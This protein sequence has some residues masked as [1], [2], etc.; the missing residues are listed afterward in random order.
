MTRF[1]V[2]AVDDDPVNLHIIGET[3]ADSG[4]DVVFANGGDPALHALNGEQA[5]DLVILDRMMP[6]LDGMQLL[7][8]LKASPRHAKL[9]VIM[10]TAAATPEQVAE[11]LS[12]GAHYYLTKPYTPAALRTI[13][14][15]ALEDVQ[16]TRELEDQATLGVESMQMLDR[17]VFGFRTIAQATKVGAL[18]A[19]L[20]PSPGTAALGL[21]EILVNAVEHGN[22]GISYAEKSALKRGNRMHEELER[23]LVDPRYAARRAVVEFERMPDVLRFTVSDEGQ[24]FDWSAFLEM[25]PKRA[26]DPNGRGIALARAMSFD[27]LDFQGCGNVVIATI[28]LPVDS[29]H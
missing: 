15:A 27:Q 11:G 1:R 28:Q 22:L 8:R 5:F 17:A 10:Q 9:Q 26:F 19:Q 7:R 25:D 20:C 2:L 3:L 23:R 29:E 24:G 14:R 21:A 18:L 16:R 6:G 4:L 12:A 13:A